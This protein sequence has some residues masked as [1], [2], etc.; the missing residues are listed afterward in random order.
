MQNQ[1]SVKREWEV[2]DALLMVRELDKEG[3]DDNDQ[4]AK[5]V[6]VLEAEGEIRYFKY[7]KNI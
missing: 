6:F 4:H 2:Q 5:R 1:N 7:F 3:E